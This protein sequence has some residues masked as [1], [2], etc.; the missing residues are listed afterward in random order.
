MHQLA[1][2]TPKRAVAWKCL[3]LQAA[4]RGSTRRF[5]PV[6]YASLSNHFFPGMEDARSRGVLWV[7]SSPKYKR[8]GVPEQSF[9]PTLTAKLVV[10]RIVTGEVV[11]SWAHD[12]RDRALEV[13]RCDLP[14]PGRLLRIRPRLAGRGLRLPAV[15]RRVGTVPVTTP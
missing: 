6:A 4:G 3:S 5:A 15:A 8:R 14:H 11:C 13:V 9:P 12:A 10:Q 1:Y 2:L 7:V